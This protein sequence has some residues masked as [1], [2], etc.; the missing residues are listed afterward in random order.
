MDT[1]VELHCFG[2]NLGE[3]KFL[4]PKYFETQRGKFKSS[5]KGHLLAKCPFPDI[6]SNL[7]ESQ[8]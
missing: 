6:L 8:G 4:D 1:S 5:K 2:M 3:I 7:S